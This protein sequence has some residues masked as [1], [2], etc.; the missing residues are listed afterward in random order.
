MISYRRQPKNLQA[1]DLWL[2]GHELK[3]EFNDPSILQLKKVV[4]TGNLHFSKK[5]YGNTPISYHS[6][7]FTY[8]FFEV[9]KK[10]KERKFIIKLKRHFV[11]TDD[12]GKSY[13][14]WLLDCLPGYYCLR[15]QV[16]MGGWPYRL[17]LLKKNMLQRV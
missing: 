13:F 9:L 12:W 6:Q 15:N 1:N 10:L 4:V 3:K 2:F 14:H 8:S 16:A 5:I 7:S 17:I 11:I